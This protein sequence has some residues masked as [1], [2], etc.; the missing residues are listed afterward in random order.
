MS[1]RSQVQ[2]ALVWFCQIQREIQDLN[3][4]RDCDL[5]VFSNVKNQRV[6]NHALVL[7]Y[8]LLRRRM[9]MM[10]TTTMMMT[11][12]LISIMILTFLVVI[13]LDGER[14]TIIM[15]SHIFHG[16]SHILP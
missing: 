9:M 15:I 7:C 8:I 3:I 2:I 12:I 6:F 10:S 4:Y 5:F 1:Q 13:Y 16:R 11:M 14:N